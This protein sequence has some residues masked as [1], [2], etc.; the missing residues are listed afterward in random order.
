MRRRVRA[1]LASAAFVLGAGQAAGLSLAEALRMGLAQHPMVRSAH[2]DIRAAEAEVEA[3]RAGYYPT[4]SVA[5]GPQ[6][7]NFDRWGYEVSATQMLYDWGRVESK[8]EGARALQRQTQAGLYLTRDEV[9]LDVAEVYLDAV[10]SQMLLATD[11]EHV[12]QLQHILEMTRTRSGSGYSDRSEPER[13]SLEIT[14]ASDVQA[15]DQGKRASAWQQLRVL[16]GAVDS[17]VLELPALPQSFGL[18]DAAGLPGLL[19]QTPSLQKVLEDTRRA[20]AEAKAAQAAL[21]PQI[22]LEAS[23]LRRA[24]GGSMISDSMLTVRLHMTPFQGNANQQRLESALQ[25]VES[26][27]WKEDALMREMT[28]EIDGLLVTSRL[29]QERQRLNERQVQETTELA[30]LYAEQFQV[31]R[32]DVIDLLNV[33]R[34]GFEA[35]RQGLDYGVQQLRIRLRIAARLGQIDELLP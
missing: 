28:R 10:L 35:R 9:L 25:R 22:N 11:R 14:R 8:V 33:Q 17:Q 20:E 18:V 30:K 13:A 3:A 6:R 5:G 1:V 32:R 23:T 16:L 7:L 26:A 19:R 27:R 4:V 24:V 21:Y 15:T 12:R 29:V 34:E 31:G 2:F